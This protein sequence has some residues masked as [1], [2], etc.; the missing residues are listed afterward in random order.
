MGIETNLALL[1][2]SISS[3]EELILAHFFHKRMNS[4]IGKY[5]KMNIEFP[6]KR[7]IESQYF[8]YEKYDKLIKMVKK[9]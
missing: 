9:S 4:I 8:G 5:E 6:L 3:D 2:A 1:S 7:T